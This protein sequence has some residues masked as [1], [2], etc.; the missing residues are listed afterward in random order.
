MELF[1]RVRILVK[2]YFNKQADVALL[3]GIESTKLSS[4]LKPKTQNNL[5]PHLIKFFDVIPDLNAEWL[6]MGKGEPTKRPEGPDCGELRKQNQ[7][8]T[9]T[10]RR[11]AE[12]NQRL[13]EELLKRQ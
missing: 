12:T 11:L 3:F 1:Q 10:N 2:T 4:Y 13:V 8:L 9:E 7:E 5:Y 6:Y